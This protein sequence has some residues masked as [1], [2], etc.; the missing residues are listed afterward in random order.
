MGGEEDSDWREGTF[1][2]L[3]KPRTGEEVSILVMPEEKNG[4]T[5]TQIIFHRND[6]RNESAGAFQA[7]MEEIKR[8]IEKSGYKLGALREPVHSGTGKIDRLRT[9]ESMRR[10]GAAQELHRTLS[11]N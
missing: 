4:V 10:K 2:V 7:R 9:S 3:S 11:Q 1:A 5:G 8:E 6:N